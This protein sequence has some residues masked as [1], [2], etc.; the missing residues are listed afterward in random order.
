M[1]KP[2]TQTSSIHGDETD[3]PETNTAE[4][5][6]ELKQQEYQKYNWKDEDLWEQFKVDFESF[7][8]EILKTCNIQVIRQL[9]SF[10]R[11]RGVKVT[12]DRHVTIVRSLLAT[13]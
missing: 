13:I 5:Y 4:E 12:K 8:E 7:T 6:I 9:R 2:S 10:L 3:S 1:A 11:T